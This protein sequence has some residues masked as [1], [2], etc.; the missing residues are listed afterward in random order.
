MANKD[1]CS[2]HT[3]A[4]ELIFCVPCHLAATAEIVGQRDGAERRVASMIIVGCRAA[5]MLLLL[6][7]L[8]AATTTTYHVAA[9][10]RLTAG[11]PPACF[12]ILIS[13]HICNIDNEDKSRFNRLSD[14]WFV[15]LLNTRR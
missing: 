5:R 6:L 4:D 14:T 13:P 12:A 15:F 11:C 8:T 7:L 2:M 3:S 9:M 1:T 10:I